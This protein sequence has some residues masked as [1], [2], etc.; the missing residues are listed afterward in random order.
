[1]QQ[2]FSNLSEAG[3]QIVDFTQQMSQLLIEL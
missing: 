2:V 3:I 1:M